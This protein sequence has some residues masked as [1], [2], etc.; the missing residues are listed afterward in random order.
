[1]A[2][3][4]QETRN[5]NTTAEQGLGMPDISRIINTILNVC[6]HKVSPEEALQ[7]FAKEY[8]DKAVL[9]AKG[10]AYTG[11][12]QLLKSSDRQ[13]VQALAENAFSERLMESAQKVAQ[14]IRSYYKKDITERDLEKQ[15]SE[16]GIKEVAF[17][18]AAALGIP[19]KLHVKDMDA[20]FQMS[21]KALTYG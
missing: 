18:A 7:G 14:V 11:L 2:T 21:S 17:E 16:S 10:K 4:D 9:L 19:E 20:V 12:E 3:M 1:M 15:L 6:N 13:E 8:K 5:P